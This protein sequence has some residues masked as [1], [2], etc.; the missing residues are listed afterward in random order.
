MIMQSPCF[1]ITICLDSS[2]IISLPSASAM[3]TCI[4]TIS[5]MQ[6]TGWGLRFIHDVTCALAPLLPF[7]YGQQHL[8][9]QS[10]IRLLWFEPTSI[11]SFLPFPA[12]Y[13]PSSAVVS[14]F[15][16]IR[17][18]HP[19]EC[20]LFHYITVFFVFFVS[21]FLRQLPPLR[22]AHADILDVFSQEQDL[23]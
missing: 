15:L 12:F 2:C 21:V 5:A 11:L 7:I 9:F 20:L 17:R 18:A 13:T 3:S 14:E 19:F 16:F 10:L 22:R 6:P 4:M 1:N 23:V 8:N